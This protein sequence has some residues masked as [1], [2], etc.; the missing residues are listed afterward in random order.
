ME[1]HSNKSTINVSTPIYPQKTQV[2]LSEEKRPSPK[3]LSKLENKNPLL[4]LNIA[5]YFN[6]F[7]PY[8]DVSTW[9]TTCGHINK[10]IKHLGLTRNQHNTVERTWNVVNKCKYMEQ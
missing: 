4:N 1:D 5:S 3:Y 10:T 2:S 6:N 9:S 7:L 8:Q